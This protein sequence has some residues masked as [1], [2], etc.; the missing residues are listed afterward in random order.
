MYFETENGPLEAD[1]SRVVVAGWTGRDEE[2]VRHHIEELEAIGVPAPSVTPLYYRVSPSLLTRSD[3]I[4]VLGD[5]TSGEAE[6]LIL[7]IDGVLWLGL[8]SDHTDRGLETFSV[9]HAKQI[10]AKP[11]AGV[12]RRLDSVADLEALELR[13]WIEEGG[14]W[15]L[16]QDGAL[17]AIKPLAELIEGAS[18]EDGDALL[19]GTLPAR[20]GVRPA[21]LFRMELRDPAGGWAIEAAYRAEMQAV[22]A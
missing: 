4:T 18:L 2:A 13:S 9:A 12:L 21:S 3:V 15:R 1:I 10:C 22:V 17:S 7:K 11:V 16:Y 8:A 20:G 19:C 5:E 14:G 6:P